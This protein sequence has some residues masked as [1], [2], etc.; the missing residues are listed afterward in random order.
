VSGFL[1][2]TVRFID[3]KSKNKRMI[4]AIFFIVSSFEILWKINKPSSQ[5]KPRPKL[6]GLIEL[7]RVQFDGN[8][9]SKMPPTLKMR[10]F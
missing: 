9:Q 10:A 1:A 8:A 2:N 3:E 4:K 7:S 5:V 6:I